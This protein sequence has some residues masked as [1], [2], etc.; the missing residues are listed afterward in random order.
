M[1]KSAAIG[2]ALSFVQAAG[3]RAQGAIDSQAAFE[4]LKRLVGTWSMVVDGKPSRDAA[5]YKLTGGGR[6]LMEDAGGMTT[7]YH[8]DVGK[9]MLT[10]YCGAGNQ[11][12]MRITEMDDRHLSFEM[13]DITNLADPKAYHSTHVD[14]VFLGDDRVDLAYRGMTDGR[15]STQLFQ[16]TRKKS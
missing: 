3:V 5:T 4:R 1:W 14:V 9:L 11:P 12:R 8:L 2:I 7:A 16:L 13:F 15:E 10:H 6:V